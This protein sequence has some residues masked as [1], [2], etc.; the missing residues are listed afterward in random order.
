TEERPPAALFASGPSVV[1]HD[2]N[3]KPATNKLKMAPTSKPSMT[4]TPTARPASTAFNHDF[5][6]EAV[7]SAARANMFMAQERGHSANPQQAFENATV[8]SAAARPPKRQTH[9]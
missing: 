2:R 7:T 9:G 4:P 1:I 3:A 8:F 6:G 5:P